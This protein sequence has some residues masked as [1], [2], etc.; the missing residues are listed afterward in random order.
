MNTSAKNSSFDTNDNT[1][2]TQLSNLYSD[3][4]K[5]VYACCEKNLSSKN[6]LLDPYYQYLRQTK[7]KMIRSIVL[8]ESA[9]ATGGITKRHIT[10]AC[11]LELMHFA[12]LIHDDIIDD[13]QARRSTASAHIHYN[14]QTAVILGDLLISKGFS[15]FASLDNADICDIVA[16]TMQ[17]IVESELHQ[18]A[19]VPMDRKSYISIIEGKT[20]CLFGIAMYLGAYLNGSETAPFWEKAGIALG[21]AFQIM[22]DV[23]DTRTIIQSKKISESAKRELW[24]LPVIVALES[25]EGHE[26]NL[27]LNYLNSAK[28]ANLAPL[29][30]MIL[31]TKS[32]EQ[33]RSCVQTYLDNASRII[34][35]GGEGKEFFGLFSELVTNEL[36]W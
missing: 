20:A 36:Y 23:S 22:D 32:M 25:L 14:T 7:G 19:A 35:A 4:L 2:I 27:F 17:R 12:S 11:A 13:S 33:V 8:F 21:M 31:E 28:Q 34:F 18:F 30:T 6:Q 5:A 16:K 29:H 15:L 24:T 1:I 10:A 9:K 26:R 3:H